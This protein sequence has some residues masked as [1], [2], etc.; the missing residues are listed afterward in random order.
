MN[1]PTNDHD[2]SSSGPGW[3]F[4]PPWASVEA[5]DETTWR[6]RHVEVRSL[7]PE[8]YAPVGVQILQLRTTG[9]EPFV[10]LSSVVGDLVLSIAQGRAVTHA[11]QKLLR[12][13]VER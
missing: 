6:S 13:V 5:S 11:L 12:L 8:Q 2:D 4:R 3:P 1:L 9:A 7:N 10:R